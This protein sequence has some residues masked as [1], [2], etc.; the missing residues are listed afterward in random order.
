MGAE[1]PS[2]ELVGSAGASSTLDEHEREERTRAQVPTGKLTSKV[3]CSKD[4]GQGM[5]GCHA[6]AYCSDGD[7]TCYCD[8]RDVWRCY[9][10]EVGPTRLVA[11][12]PGLG[13]EFGWSVALSGD[14]LAV[15]SPCESSA[16]GNLS[17]D[18]DNNDCSEAGAAYIF[19]RSNDAWAQE[20]FLKARYP[21]EE[22]RFGESIALSGDT[23]AV[24]VPG[25]SSSSPGVNA[26]STHGDAPNS[27]AVY[28]FTRS[29]SKWSQHAYVKASNAR[30]GDRFGASVALLGETLVVGAPGE[31][32]DIDGAVTSDMNHSG[33]I[34]IF[35]RR[36][37]DWAET[38]RLKAFD[39]R[40][41]TRFGHAVALSAQVLLAG[42]P[43]E[44][45]G[46]GEDPSEGEPQSGAAYLFDRSLSQSGSGGGIKLKGVPSRAHD[47]SGEYVAA[48][49][50]TM[51]V[52]APKASSARDSFGQAIPESGGVYL[53]EQARPE[54]WSQRTL[55]TD[56]APLP[57]GRFGYGLALSD[58]TLVVG[59]TGQI[60]AFER[61]GE[62]WNLRGH[63]IATELGDG[64]GQAVALDSGTLA[65][66]APLS[67][68]IELEG[69]AVFVW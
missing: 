15:G 38:A 68:S 3:A 45:T 4:F 32:N 64:F 40:P 10:R 59:A 46:G 35:E 55:L 67:D 25:E 29:G 66:G 69:G 65:V 17:P 6:P 24:G 16:F 36:G 53:F 63:L 43:G 39:P 12:N 20:A 54:T 48:A 62:L 57:Y 52:G 37:G 8:S 58:R 26:D 21:H 1:A 27:G 41:T 44:S 34:Y 9:A 42:S 2:A 31:S 47:C 14:T 28:V 60:F 23:V 49:S 51:V 19:V 61:V 13:D 33:A 18:P 11:S 22:D 56:P 50:D 30:S 7:R 5:G